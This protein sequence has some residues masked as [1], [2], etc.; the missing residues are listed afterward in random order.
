M[1]NTITVW[2]D[3]GCPWAS[4]FVWR[5]LARRAALGLEEAVRLDH[6]CFPLELVNERPTPRAVVD[7]EVEALAPL[8]PDAG[9]RAWSR[10]PSAYPVTTLPAL[11]AV[12]A[13]KAQGLDASERLDLALRQAFWRDNR[14]ISLRHEVLAAAESA[15]VD[16]AALAEALDAG[17]ARQAVV[18]DWRAF[19]EAGVQGSPHV[20]LPDGSDVANPGIE[21]HWE[22][23]K[24]GGKPVVDSDDVGAIDALLRRAAEAS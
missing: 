18:D 12:Q 24:P 21:Q 10:D 2:S 20:F 17:T 4:L 11:E 8:V 6:R 19:K 16:V 9:W 13:A 7:A 23:P 22:G 5:A 15:G 14:C 1:A 3:V